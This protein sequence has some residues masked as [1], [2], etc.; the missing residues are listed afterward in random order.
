M[1]KLPTEKNA[2]T[3]TWPTQIHEL[4]AYS[5]IGCTMSQTVVMQHKIR[6]PWQI[7]KIRRKHNL[8]NKLI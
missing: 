4:S 8:Q 1:S 6:A 2:K 7:V 5:G 3:K